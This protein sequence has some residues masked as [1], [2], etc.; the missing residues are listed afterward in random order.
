MAPHRVIVGA[1][2]FGVVTIFQLLDSKGLGNT[3]TVHVD[4]AVS[5]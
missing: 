2:L 1:I 3:Y 4:D 5:G